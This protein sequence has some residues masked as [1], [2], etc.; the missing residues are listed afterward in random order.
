MMFV[1]KRLSSLTNLEL[2]IQLENDDL[3]DYPVPTTSECSVVKK[4]IGKKKLTTRVQKS[5]ESTVRKKMYIL[6]QYLTN[7]TQPIGT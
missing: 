4:K 1:L 7:L 5:F 6:P 2:G 3:A